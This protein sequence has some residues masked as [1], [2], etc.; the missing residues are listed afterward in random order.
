MLLC[1]NIFAYYLYYVYYNIVVDMDKIYQKTI[2]IVLGVIVV[3]ANKGLSE[4]L[5]NFQWKELFWQ[6]M[7]KIQIGF[8]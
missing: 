8:E 3:S 7:R 2:K 4:L 5:R 1:I 6:L